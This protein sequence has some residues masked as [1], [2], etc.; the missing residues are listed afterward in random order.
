MAESQPLHPQQRQLYLAALQPPESDQD[1]HAGYRLDFAIGTTFSLDLIAL[2]SV[3]VACTFRGRQRVMVKPIE[4]PLALLK[5]LRQQSR[6]MLVFVQAGR[7]HLPKFQPLLSELEHAVIEARAPRGGSFHPKLWI[8]R[9]V[10]NDNDQ[11]VRYRVLCLSR[12]LT[13]DRCWDTFIAVE[14]SL[15]HDLK[16]GYRENQPLIDFLKELPT[17]GLREM[18]VEQRQSH[19]RIC[20]ELRFVKFTP[21]QP[22]DEMTWHLWDWAQQKLGHFRIKLIA[23]W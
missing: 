15:R 4:N 11:D 21:P 8:L 6:R 3:P 14:G 5:A 9:Y 23:A 7:I 12:N 19:E 18:D 13:F 22:F 2:L 16:S 17:A 20:T 1:G 10:A